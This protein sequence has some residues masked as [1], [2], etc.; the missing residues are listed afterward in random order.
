MS[1]IVVGSGVL[2]ETVVGLL[3][4]A[5]R[6][7][8][9]VAPS[10]KV[11]ALK[12]DSSV[13]KAILQEDSE[14][15][16][17]FEFIDDI[18]QQQKLA[19]KNFKKINVTTD[20]SKIEAADQIIDA[21]SADESS[22]F[23]NTAKA[24]PNATIISLNGEKSPIHSNHVSVKMYSPIHETK[25]AKMFTN[26]KVSKKTLEEVNQL[27]DSMG[28]TVLSE[29]DS[30]VADRL[31]LDMQQVEKSS[32]LSKLISTLVTPLNA[33]ATPSMPKEQY[34]LF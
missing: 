16:I 28:L 30:R 26:S 19:D 3:C 22:L 11:N 31:V 23:I 17:P 34:L 29:E 24:V 15:K 2:A 9:L 8:S 32:S 18:R 27:L 13:I 14:K 12:F 4:A 21:C 20:I 6:R 25:T 33:P 10:G 5:G 7:V 1:S